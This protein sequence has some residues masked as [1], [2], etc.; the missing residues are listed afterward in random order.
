MSELPL[1]GVRAIC[2][3]VGYVAPEA[4]RFL[5]EFGA[6]AILIESSKKMD[7]SRGIGMRYQPDINSSYG[8]NDID[9]GLKSMVLDVSDPWQQ[10]LLTRLVAASDIFIENLAYA[11]TENLGLGYGD[12]VKVR[13]DIIY[14]S[15]NAFGRTGPYTEFRTFGPNLPFVSGLASY[16]RLPSDPHPLGPPAPHPD[17]IAGKYLFQAILVALMERQKTGKGA[18]IE[19]SQA[20]VAAALLGEAYA[21]PHL[22][23]REPDPPANGHQVWAP[24]G[25]Y[26]CAG[27][28]QW[29]AIAVQSDEQWSR[30]IAALGWEPDARF[31]EAAGR[32]QHREEIDLA[33]EGWTSQQTPASAAEI[34]LGAGVPASAVLTNVGYIEAAGQRGAIVEIEHPSGGTSKH[35]ANPIRMHDTPPRDH[36]RAP[37]FGEHTAEIC[38][39]I[40]KLPEEEIA[41]L[42]EAGRIPDDGQPIK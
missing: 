34:L 3:G 14:A 30:L 12:L 38:R 17:H 19:C 4:A 35:C 24:H 27:E 33:I 15:S 37:C 25:V 9:R 11:V 21:L 26:R 41:R 31:A 2:F 42:V 40:L 22:M 8:F 7:I 20:E 5:A 13:P 23:G 16:W 6:E 18:F 28:D 29:C 32:R 1:S 39:D 10:G 36:V